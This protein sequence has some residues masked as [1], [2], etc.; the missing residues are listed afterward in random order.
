MS[1]LIPNMSAILRNVTS[2]LR[3]IIF[4][5]YNEYSESNNSLYI[6]I[7]KRDIGNLCISILIYFMAVKNQT[8][9]KEVFLTLN[10]FKV[11]NAK[12]TEVFPHLVTI[13]LK[14]YVGV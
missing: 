10:N 6:N 4:E 2:N 5:I 9:N 11:H 1:F 13:N 8:E 12:Y 14:I 7:G 3:K